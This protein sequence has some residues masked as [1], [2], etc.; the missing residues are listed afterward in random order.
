MLRVH[1]WHRAIAFACA[2]QEGLELS[3]DDSVE[4]G[5][6]GLVPL[7][8]HQRGSRMSECPSSPRDLT[9]WRLSDAKPRSFLLSAYPLPGAPGSGYNCANAIAEDCGIEKWWRE[10]EYVTAAREADY[11]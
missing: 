2:R 9:E 11:I 10:Q 4:R 1:E 8:R 5:L 6:L 7:V 3:T